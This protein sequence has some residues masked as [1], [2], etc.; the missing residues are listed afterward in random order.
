MILLARCVQ[1]DFNEALVLAVSLFSSAPKYKVGAGRVILITGALLPR[2]ASVSSSLLR[3]VVLWCVVRR[4][5]ERLH[6]RRDDRPVRGP[7]RKDG[8]KCCVCTNVLLTGFRDDG[9]SCR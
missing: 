4:C 7:V 2:T 5:G 3:C 8:R 9:G 1:S 6:I